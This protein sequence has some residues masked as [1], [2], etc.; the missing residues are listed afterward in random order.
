M[1]PEPV[2]GQEPEVNPKNPC[3]LTWGIWTIEATASVSSFR[4]SREHPADLTYL[5]EIHYHG[6]SDSGTENL[7]GKLSTSGA[8]SSLESAAKS[9]KKMKPLLLSTHCEEDDEDWVD[10][11][12]MVD[13]ST[14][15]DAACLQL[16]SALQNLGFKD[17]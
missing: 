6:D 11:Y 16:K 13:V 12:K 3:E 9:A 15:V 4:D 14:I 7:F 1:N 10:Y 5:V 8:H 17:D 2:E